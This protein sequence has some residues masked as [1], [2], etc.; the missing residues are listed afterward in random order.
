MKKKI[1]FDKEYSDES[2]I[3]LPEDIEWMDL[4]GIDPDES[5]FR[6]GTFHVTITWSPEEFND[7]E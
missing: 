4:D 2:I 1:V 7:E 6:P 3:D 5:G